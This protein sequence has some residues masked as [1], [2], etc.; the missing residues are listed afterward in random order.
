[1]AT[2]RPTKPRPVRLTGPERREQLLDVTKRIVGEDGLH[3]V[4]IDRVAREAGITRPIVYEH[5]S[6]LAGLLDALLTR[7]A[8]FARE[9]LATALRLVPDGREPAEVLLGA[10]AGY[11]QAVLDE[12]V[13]WQLVL[14]PPEGAPEFIR[15]HIENDRLAIID[16]LA[17]VLR[18]AYATSGGQTTPDAELTAH[19]LS[20]MSDY[21][22]RLM[23][24]DPQTYTMDR[25]L[26]HAR[27]A[28]S[29]FA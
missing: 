11:L 4:S 14:T 17:L 22:S 5:F 3:A 6:N 15:E 10:L 26:T 23:L 12:P 27:W 16:Q 19:T 20:A 2:G 18:S 13:T 29:R 25:L 9:Q 8:T 28:L 24:R 7:E 21:W 1:M